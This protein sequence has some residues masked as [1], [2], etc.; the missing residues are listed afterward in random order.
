LGRVPRQNAAKPEQVF[1]R[2]PASARHGQFY[3]ASAAERNEQIMDT[4]KKA[5]RTVNVAVAAATVTGAVPIPFADAPL[6]VGEQIAMMA[7]IARI[8]EIDIREDG[9]KTLATAALG[10]GGATIVEKTAVFGIAKLIPG[11]G[12]LIGGAVSGAAAGV[13]TSWVGMAFIEF[14]KAVRIGGLNERSLTSKEGVA[15]FLGYFKDVSKPW[16]KP[17]R[18]RSDRLGGD[19]LSEEGVD[20]R[21]E[22]GG[23][24]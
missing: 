6:L 17:A 9:L 2:G 19:D 23:E 8:F 11:P 3:A 13:I 16:E 5:E 7:G 21:S 24:S 10:V 20:D 1:G 12:W 14:C 22:E 15:A 4:I 18:A